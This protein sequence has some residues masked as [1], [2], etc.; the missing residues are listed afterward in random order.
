MQR[1]SL[2][3]TREQ[4]REDKGEDGERK[5]RPP[6]LRAKG[7]ERS[8]M[9]ALLANHPHHFPLQWVL[10]WNSTLTLICCLVNLVLN[11]YSVECSNIL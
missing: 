6:P 5:M 3:E 10:L 7:K 4:S 9:Y 8:V 1:E 2:N 11:L